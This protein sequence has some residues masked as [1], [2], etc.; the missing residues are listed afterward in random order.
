MNVFVVPAFNEERNLPR[1]LEDLE[2]RP[3]L[4][5]PGRLIVVD[6]GSED[7]TA[8]VAEEHSG[9]LPVEVIRLRSNQGPGCA[10]DRGFRRALELALPDGYVVTLEGDTTSDLDALEKMLSLAREGADVVLASHHDGGEL[11]NV[12]A[13][14][15]FLSRAA[16]FAVRR[17]AG[18]E[19]RTVSSFFRVYRAQALECG[20][21]LYG[22]AFIREPG[23]ACKA[24]ILVKLDRLGLSIVEV[25]VSLDWSRRE[26]TSKLSVLPTVAGYARLVIRHGA[27][28]RERV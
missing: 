16:A 20:Y 25:P 3:S 28:S 9:L 27:L 6:D 23:F 15:R 14:R 4:W 1:L 22:D 19:A 7:R 2:S 26:G 17:S 5:S 24:E 18:L 12:G 21:A 8:Q 13:H 11:V 10:F